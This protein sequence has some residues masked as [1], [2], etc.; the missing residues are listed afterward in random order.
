MLCLRVCPEISSFTNIQESSEDIGSNGAAA[1]W[2]NLIRHHRVYLHLTHGLLSPYNTK[3]DCIDRCIGASSTDNFPEETIENTL[4]PM[5][6]VGMRPSYWS[7]GGRSDP[8][9]PE[10]LLYSLQSDL[11]LVDEIKIHP[12]KGMLA[13]ISIHLLHMALIFFTLQLFSSTGIQ[14]IQLRTFASKWVVQSRLYALSS[15]SS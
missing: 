14:Y 1:E 2:E 13:N 10:F 3:K 4:D 9:V 7:S 15:M 6:R 5:D 12:F 11:C 8:S